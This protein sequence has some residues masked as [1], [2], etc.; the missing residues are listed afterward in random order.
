MV[1]SRPGE[2]A[3]DN[4]EEETPIISPREVRATPIGR[5]YPENGTVSCW[6][7]TDNERTRTMAPN[8]DRTSALDVPLPRRLSLGVGASCVLAVL[9]ALG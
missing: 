7:P 8:A 2:E 3:T 6:A 4:E 1:V 5:I 9:A